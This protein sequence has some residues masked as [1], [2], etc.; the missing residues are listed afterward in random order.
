MKNGNRNRWV[1]ACGAL[2]VG[3]VVL[4]LGSCGSLIPQVGQGFGFAFGAIPAEVVGCL[5]VEGAG[6]TCEGVIIPGAVV[7]SD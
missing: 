5:I 4:Q 7:L 6:Q 2:A 1:K 3:S